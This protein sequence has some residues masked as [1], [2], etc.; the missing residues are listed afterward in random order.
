ME[1][2]QSHSKKDEKKIDEIE[3]EIKEAK[4]KNY[5]QNHSQQLAMLFKLL[6]KGEKNLPKK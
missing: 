2:K 4:L 6:I 5:A 1:T 3:T